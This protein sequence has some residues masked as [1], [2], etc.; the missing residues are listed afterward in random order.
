VRLLGVTRDITERKQVEE[1][2]N[3]L[4]AELDHRVKNALA[5]VAALVSRTRETTTSLPEFTAALDGR[6]KSM[7]IAHEL[8]SGRKWHGLP[9]GQLIERELEP[10]AAAGSVHVDGPAEVMLKAEAGQAL[11]MVVHELVTNAA[12]Y[13]ALS[14][15]GGRVSVRWR[16]LATNGTGSHLALEW[17]ESGGPAIAPS[18]RAGYG[19]S[20]I[21]DLIPY[22][23]GGT[24][25]LALA[26]EGARCRLRIPSRWLSRTAAGVRASGSGSGTMAAAPAPERRRTGTGRG[27]NASLRDRGLRTPR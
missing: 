3:L 25:D 9:L 24:V 17:E 21:R 15:G 26:P 16:R 8:L 4:V 1:H 14:V 20:V 2:K 22:E 13:G 5:V 23:L 12:K 19:T 7:A 11:A 10:Y 6:I 18:A 27:G